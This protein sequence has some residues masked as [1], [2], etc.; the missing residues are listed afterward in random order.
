M[1]DEQERNMIQSSMNR[2]LSG[3]KENPYLAQRVISASKGEPVVKKKI[4]F[5]MVLVIALILVAVTALAISLSAK[6]IWKQSQEKMNTS[7]IVNVISDDTNA[8]FSAEEAIQIARA[9]IQGKYGTTDDELDGMGI[10]PNYIARGWDGETDNDPSKWEV[11]FSSRTGVNLDYSTLNYGPEGEYR[12]YI[13]AET[14]EVTYCHWYTNDF[15]SRAQRV[16]NCGNYDELYARYTQPEFRSL[17]ADQQE[18]WAKQ[19]EEKGY[20]LISEDVM[21][22]DLLLNDSTELQFCELYDIADNSLPQVAA[23]WDTVEKTY[24]FKAEL[25][26]KYAYVATLPDWNTGT[27]EVCI[28]YSYNLE[29]SRHIAMYSAE[30]KVFSYAN[31][32][33]LFMISFEKGTTDVV[34]VT[35]ITRSESIREKS[36]VTEGTVLAC[37]D[38]SGADLMEFDSI[39]KTM[40]LAMRRMDAAE[41]DADSMNLVANTYLRS[42][43][44][45]YVS[46][47]DK[48][49]DITPWFAETTAW[50]TQ[51]PKRID[52]Y[53]I[54]SKYGENE[55]FW[56]L[57]LQAEYSLESTS[58]PREGELTQD[59]AIAIAVDAVK[60]KYGQNAFSA[61][62]NNYAV[63]CQLYRF[64]NE[65]EVTRWHIYFTDDP[66][67]MENGYKVLFAYRDGQPWSEPE[68][69]DIND[70]GN[71]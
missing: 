64:E 52:Y 47:V 44:D 1:T 24:G 57:E 69:N 61:L 7:G 55:R 25:L 60:K 46:E 67:R 9:A 26:Q 13:N 21:R 19:L 16:W 31:R 53:E 11:W 37:T 30:I 43:G 17:P 59:E 35:H 48:P 4:S 28:H 40:V 54:V 39:Y 23:A 70:Q 58:V 18:Y 71:G 22:H 5:G 14:K 42:L 65:G 6:E 41:E 50:D 34:H 10:Y 8:D 51:L 12:V 62:G 38:W 49:I 32:C 36:P 27:D 66:A 3:L 56:P 29:F 2:R 20:I 45:P 15:W 63:G 68:V 33:G